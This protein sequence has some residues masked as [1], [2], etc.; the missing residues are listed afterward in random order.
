MFCKK[1]FLR[2]FAKFT[3]KHL[4]QNLILIKLQNFIKKTTLAQ[5]LFCEFCEISKNKFF[6]E[7]LWTTS[8]H[9]LNY[10]QMLDNN[11]V[12]VDFINRFYLT[13]FF[14]LTSLERLITYLYRFFFV[15]LAKS[16]CMTYD[17]LDILIRK[18][19]NIGH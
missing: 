2:N 12:V 1:G 13:L 14:Y 5:V 8:F 9:A 16:V 18:Y 7:Q 6:T 15:L 10:L 19:K 4:C 11:R 17:L 3:G